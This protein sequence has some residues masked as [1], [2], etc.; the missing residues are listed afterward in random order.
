MQYKRYKGQK[1]KKE[2]G[3][4]KMISFFLSHSRSLISSQ[5]I[6]WWIS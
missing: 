5:I 1:E 6:G 2:K 4:K 3:K